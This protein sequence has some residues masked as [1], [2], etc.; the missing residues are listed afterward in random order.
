MKFRPV[1]LQAVVIG[2]LAWTACAFVLTMT[3]IQLLPMGILRWSYGMMAPYQGDTPWNADFAYEGRLPSGT[4]ET[5]D[6][7]H[8]FPQQQGERNV[9]KFIRTYQAEGPAAHTEKFTEFAQILLGHE[10]D[11]GKQYDAVRIWY[12]EWPRS[13]AGYQALHLSTFTTRQFVTQ[14]E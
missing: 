13:P 1:L 9:R 3:K 5:I 14:V 7:D 12:E 11:R 8:Y 6:I 10:R 4:W 2:Y